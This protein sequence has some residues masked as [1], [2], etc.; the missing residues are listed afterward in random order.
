MNCNGALEKSHGL[1][2]RN[3]GLSGKT[4]IEGKYLL[5]YVLEVHG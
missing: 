2:Y 5:I 1:D 4:N 3:F